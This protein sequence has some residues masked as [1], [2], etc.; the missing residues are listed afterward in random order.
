MWSDT[1]LRALHACARWGLSQRYTAST[2]PVLLPVRLRCASVRRLCRA[3]PGG[4]RGFPQ[5]A[6]NP[7]RLRCEQLA[8]VCAIHL[9]PRWPTPIAAAHKP[10]ISTR[11]QRSEEHTSE[12]QSLMSI[13]YD[14][15]CLK[16][17]KNK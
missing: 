15:F 7:M 13:S 11:G 4:S 16:K 9:G 5:A 14:V 3:V 17:K 2:S 6:P 1:H 12:L 8:P 10:A